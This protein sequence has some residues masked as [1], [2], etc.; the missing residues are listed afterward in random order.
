MFAGQG[1]QGFSA[2]GSSSW[3]QESQDR[4]HSTSQQ[5]M[6][7][8][9]QQSSSAGS[10]KYAKDE[11]IIIKVR[12]G[13]DVRRL[14]LL[15]EDLN[16][17]ELLIM[18]QRVFKGKIN[19]SD[20]VIVKYKDEDGDMITI[21]D[22]ADLTFALLQTDKVLKTQLF[23]NGAGDTDGVH[24]T[25]DASSHGWQ[26][27][28]H[29]LQEKLTALPST[30]NDGIHSVVE[31]VMRETQS[32]SGGTDSLAL[33]QGTDNKQKATTHA[34]DHSSAKAPG[35]ALLE[36]GGF[37]ELSLKGSSD[38]RRDS[39]MSGST[40]SQHGHAGSQ[41]HTPFVQNQHLQQN[42][43]AGQD[44]HGLTKPTSQQ[45]QHAYQLPSAQMASHFGQQGTPQQHQQQTQPSHLHQQQQQQT[46]ANLG[47]HAP[48]QPLQHQQ[49]PQPGQYGQAGQHP[50][51]QG[52]FPGHPG[53][54]AQQ[55]QPGLG[56]AGLKAQ[57]SFP[58]TPAGSS[59]PGSTSSTGLQ[60]QFMVQQQQQYPGGAPPPR[61][62]TPGQQQPGSTQMGAASTPS[63]GPPPP[64]AMGSQFAAPGANPY[65]RLPGAAGAPGGHMMGQSAFGLQSPGSVVGQPPQQQPQ[66]QQAGASQVYP[67]I[68]QQPGQAQMGQQAQGYAYGGPP[69]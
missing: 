12:L 27:A 8:S 46:Q 22:D 9:G 51:Q 10:H 31:K 50:V 37:E 34:K 36:N 48:Q 67:G 47:L 20:Q 55:Q 2:T 15:N 19:S 30:I 1:T 7:T 41:A 25:G 32:A 63:V 24:H 23:L 59:L 4:Q 21:A 11:R 3:D 29:Q 16:Y 58:P 68:Y 52:A 65:A 45:S 69:R 66:Q 53:Q 44:L 6:N 28:F 35:S 60:Q 33:T 13:N 18:M 56:A 40:A 17:D 61:T 43:L 5:A 14:P 62:A 39:E 54:A 26:D 42:G 57:Y 38:G 64:S 49:A